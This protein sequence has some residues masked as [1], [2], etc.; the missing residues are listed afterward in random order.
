MMIRK[1][2]A[3]IIGASLFVAPLSAM[4]KTGTVT[5]KYVTMGSGR[6]YLGVNVADV[7]SDRVAALKLKEERGVEVTLVDQDSPA[8][9]AGMKEH[10]V[11][12]DFNGNRVESTEQLTR[13]I[14]E[15][16]PGREVNLGISRDGQP[17]QIKVALGDRSKTWTTSG[18]YHIMPGM[19]MPV[20]PDMP[21]MPE[22]PDF[23][24]FT[25]VTSGS[26]TNAGALVDNLTP[27]LGDFFG[28]KGGAGV[29][30]RS[31]EKGSAAES[32][33][34]KAGDVIVKVDTDRIE[35]R[36]DWRRA[37]RSRKTGK[38]ALTVVRDKREQALT[39][40]LPEPKLR[41][42]SHNGG[43]VIEA[44][45]I[46]IDIANLDELENIGPVV[47]REMIRVQPQIELQLRQSGVQLK[48]T[49]ELEMQN[50]QKELRESLKNIH[51]EVRN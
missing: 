19:V 27:Q 16:P 40:T 33:G 4:A 11:I 23:Q 24:D 49:L 8:G 38:V 10:D 42:R 39:L 32:A 45:D 34:L 43:I 47:E 51:V 50:L 12:L 2:A 20:M 17:M 28:V 14:R 25:I 48:K 30:V 46:D 1:T 6:A 29:L 7:S 21:E 37:L 31:V 5:M 9:K 18:G 26:S 41:E 22:M 3:L 36:S 44:P 13:M 35:N 15:T